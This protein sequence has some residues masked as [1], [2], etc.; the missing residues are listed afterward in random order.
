MQAS[1]VQK[2]LNIGGRRVQLSI[3]VSILMTVM[4]FLGKERGYHLHAVTSGHSS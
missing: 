2:T 3:W 1:F 4:A